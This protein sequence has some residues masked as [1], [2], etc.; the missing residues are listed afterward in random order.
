MERSIVS[1]QPGAP[2]DSLR[3]TLLTAGQ[4]LRNAVTAPKK[5]TD[6]DRDQ[7]LTDAIEREMIQR[8]LHCW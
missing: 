3:N 6:P 5:P 2:F 8:E 4:R 1:P 7:L